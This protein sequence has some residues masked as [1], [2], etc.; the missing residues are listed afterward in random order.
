MAAPEVGNAAATSGSRTTTV[1]PAVY[2]EAYLLGAARL[3]SYSG[4]ISSSP[5]R[6]ASLPLLEAFFII[7]SFRASRAPGADDADGLA[8]VGVHDRQQTLVLGDAQEDESFFL[9]RVARIGHNAAQR[10]SKDG[11]RLFE[12]DFVL[13]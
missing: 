4:R 13:A 1:P 6:P 3:K 7:F 2:R 8:A 10:I 5:R 11:R 9:V 12:G